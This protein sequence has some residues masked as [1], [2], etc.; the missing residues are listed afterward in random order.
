MSAFISLNAP[1]D[2][3]IF[4]I[5]GSAHVS[6]TT[7]FTDIFPSFTTAIN[8]SSQPLMR[9]NTW[10]SGT[11]WIQKLEFNPWLAPNNIS[12]HMDRLA[13]AMTNVIRSALSKEM[14][15]EEAFIQETYVA[16]YWGWLAFPFTLLLFSLVFLVA[17]KLKTDREGAI[18]IWKMSAMPT[19]VY[20]LPQEVQKSLQQDDHVRRRKA[21]KVRIRLPPDRGWRLSRQLVASPTSVRRNRLNEP[22]HIV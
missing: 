1:G 22:V 2:T 11:P 8:E 12:G 4:G 19:L 5:E 20:S 13:R 3:T 16:V 10:R 17:R 7:G 21:R 9:W 6:I 14:L 15:A 18:D